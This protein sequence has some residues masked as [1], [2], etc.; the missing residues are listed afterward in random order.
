MYQCVFKVDLQV[1]KCRVHLRDA[2]LTTTLRKKT[3]K[4]IEKSFVI[5]EE[6]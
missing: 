5:T 3:L 1:Y 2:D 6:N 4:P